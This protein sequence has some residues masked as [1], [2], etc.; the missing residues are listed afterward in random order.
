[1][2]NCTGV[3]QKASCSCI[4]YRYAQYQELQPLCVVTLVNTYTAGPAQLRCA[5]TVLRNILNRQVSLYPILL[6]QNSESVSLD[7]L[8]YADLESLR[9]RK[10]GLGTRAIPGGQRS[11]LNTK[12]YLIVTYTVEFDR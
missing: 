11:A 2:P 10:A 8:T 6:L 4:Y 9:N 5:Q 12:R 3:V 1:M 7:L